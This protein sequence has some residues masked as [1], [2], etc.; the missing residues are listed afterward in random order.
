[1]RS[2]DT[3]DDAIAALYGGGVSAKQGERLSGGCVNDARM[4]ELSDGRRLFAKSNSA[5]RAAMFVAEAK[6]LRSLRLTKAIRV[7]KPLAL[8]RSPRR[9][10]LLTEYLGGAIGDDDYWRR[11]GEGLARLH[12]APVE[13]TFG[14]EYDNYIGLSEQ[15]NA[16]DEN[17]ARFFARYRLAPQLTT[18]RKNDALDQ[19]T[20][21]IIERVIRDIDS[22]LPAQPRVSLLHGDLWGG[23]VIA[24]DRGD[25]ALIDPAIYRGDAVA[26]IAMTRLFG[27]FPERFYNAYRAA[28]PLGG[29]WLEQAERYNLY[30]MLNHLNLFGATYLGSV[31]ALAKRYR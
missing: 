13:A 16:I 24:D 11:L 26:D 27:G 3:I 1:M 12:L 8:V 22:W 31:R 21:R 23:N 30:H 7:P 19:Q 28:I 18:A 9:A 17:W 29:D 4:V 14:L 10:T 6:G 2:Y 20:A 15:R 5:D 25:P